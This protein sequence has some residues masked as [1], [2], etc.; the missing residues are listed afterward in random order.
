MTY[1][2]ITFLDNFFWIKFTP[3]EELS[4]NSFIQIQ[5]IQIHKKDF[6]IFTASEIDKWFFSDF[7]FIMLIFFQVFSFCSCLHFPLLFG[8]INVEAQI[9]GEFHLGQEKFALPRMADSNFRSYFT[10]SFSAWI[11]SA[12]SC[13]DTF[14]TD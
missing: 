2:L 5:Q 12:F 8:D 11:L 9:C 14:Q 3:A 13:F 10:D 4:K 1:L 7:L 6:C